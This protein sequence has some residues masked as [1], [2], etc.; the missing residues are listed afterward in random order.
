MSNLVPDHAVK[1]CIFP[2]SCIS[3]VNFKQSESVKVNNISHG[4]NLVNVDLDLMSV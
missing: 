1:V 3:L 4:E 2:V